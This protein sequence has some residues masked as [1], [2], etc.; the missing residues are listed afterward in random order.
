[1]NLGSLCVDVPDEI[2]ITPSGKRGFKT[3]IHA[4]GREP[5]DLLKHQPPRLKRRG[6]RGKRRKALGYQIRIDEKLAIR[7]SRQEFARESGLAGAIRSGNDVD[8]RAHHRS[9][10]H[11]GAKGRCRVLGTRRAQGGQAAGILRFKICLRKPK[12]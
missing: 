6:L 8:G 11:G 4:L 3:E 1:M 12:P 10:Y 9:A 5:L 2:Q 7:I